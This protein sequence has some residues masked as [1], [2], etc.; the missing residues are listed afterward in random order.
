MALQNVTVEVAFT[1]T[2]FADPS[3]LTWTDLSSYVESWSTNR[4][5]ADEQSQ[6]QAGTATVSLQNTD[7]RFDPDNGSSPYSPNLLPGVPIRISTTFS[8]TK[9]YLFWGF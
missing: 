3:T 6:M 4:G 9:Y 5:R 2:P 7:G 1:S 8:A